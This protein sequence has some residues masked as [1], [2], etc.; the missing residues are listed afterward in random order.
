MKRAAWALVAMVVAVTGSA[1]A[2]PRDGRPPVDEQAMREAMR[3]AGEVE[4]DFASSASY[5]HYLR[6]RLHHFQGD[7]RKALE[8]LRLALISDE[9]SPYLLVAVAE[10]YARMSEL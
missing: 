6:S 3:S 9:N 1:H 10:E 2:R 4:E 7:H 8:E 5:A